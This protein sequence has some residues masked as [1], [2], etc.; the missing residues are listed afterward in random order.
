MCTRERDCHRCKSF[1]LHKV[2]FTIGTAATLIYTRLAGC[3]IDTYRTY[4]VI[5]IADEEAEEIRQRCLKEFR[6]ILHMYRCKEGSKLLKELA[7]IF[8]EDDY[9]DGSLYG[10]TKEYLLN[11]L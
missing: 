7:D 4:I 3:G 11:N 2:V 9:L 6:E 5:L 1:I 10:V 8:V